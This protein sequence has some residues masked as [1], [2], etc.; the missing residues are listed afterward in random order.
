[1]QLFDYEKGDGISHVGSHPDRGKVIGNDH[2][3]HSGP[4]LGPLQERSDHLFI[5][6]FDGFQLLLEA[7][8]MA[9][10]VRGFNVHVDQI[11]G[12]ERR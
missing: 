10:L 7:A 11:S 8:L 12:L 3:T 5:K 1:M 2:Q 9:C 4:P 6:G